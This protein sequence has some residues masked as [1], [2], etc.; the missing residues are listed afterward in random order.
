MAYFD[1]RKA[2]DEGKPLR[3]IASTGATNW[4]G[5]QLPDAA[6]R[7]SVGGAGT[8]IYL[9]FSYADN[10][11]ASTVDAVEV[12]AAQIFACDLQPEQVTCAV[13]SKTGTATNIVIVV[14]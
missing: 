6:K 12:P 4:Q 7:V 3:T 5:V 1:M 11:A 9:S 13:I 14:E 8:A 10:A 2:F